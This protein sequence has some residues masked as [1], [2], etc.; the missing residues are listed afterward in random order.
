MGVDLPGSVGSALPTLTAIR[1]HLA[2][3]D[4]IATAHLDEAIEIARLFH[5]SAGLNVLSR[6][7]ALDTAQR[8]TYTAL[9]NTI[10]MRLQRSSHRR[11]DNCHSHVVHQLR[12]AVH[13]DE[14]HRGSLTEGFEAAST[15][16]DLFMAESIS[17]LVENTD[18][19]VVFAAHNWHIKKTLVD[20]PDGV[21]LPA[22]HHLATSLGDDYQAIGL[23]SVVGRTA[24]AATP[25][26][27]PEGFVFREPPLPPAPP[28]SLE[29]GLPSRSPWYL[30][31][32]TGAGSAIT[33]TPPEQHAHVRL[34][35][36]RASLRR[37]RARVGQSQ[38]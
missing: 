10:L 21:L 24:I 38:R 36:G 13:L 2:A 31:D 29:A 20:Q 23:T 27:H 5:D 19:R 28:E 37:L 32:L 7:P 4:P 11:S 15:F 22:G 9:L 12:A 1:A 8:D 35:H 34:L 16:R 18:A 6:Y 30:T 17:R 26:D 25:S 14:P 3:T 33:T